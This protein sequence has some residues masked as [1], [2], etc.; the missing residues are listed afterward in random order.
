MNNL[1]QGLDFSEDIQLLLA[2]A[3]KISERLYSSSDKRTPT[4]ILQLYNCTL[5]QNVFSSSR[6]V[7]FSLASIYF[8]NV[9]DVELHDPDN[10]RSSW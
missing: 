4:T 10:C 1:I 3:V 8:R 7:I 6:L 5:V 2:T 9:V